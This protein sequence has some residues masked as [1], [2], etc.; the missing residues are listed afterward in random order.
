LLAPIELRHLPPGLRGPLPLV[1]TVAQRL[2]AQ[3]S[4]DLAAGAA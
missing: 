1:L 2:L 4:A 3:R